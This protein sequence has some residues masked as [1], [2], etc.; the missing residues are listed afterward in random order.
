MLAMAAAAV[1][2]YMRK[3]GKV[4]VVDAGTDPE[5]KSESLCALLSSACDTHCCIVF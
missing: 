1:V 4:K 2:L 5:Q 3:K